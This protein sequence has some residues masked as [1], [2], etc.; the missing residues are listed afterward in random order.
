MSLGLERSQNSGVTFIDRSASELG[1]IMA[2]IGTFQS[3]NLR[4]V[5]IY[6]L[7]IRGKASD[8]RCLK[9]MMLLNSPFLV[10]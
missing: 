8:T 2:P 4:D 7:E 3:R 5:R 9:G 1:K 10:E 6:T